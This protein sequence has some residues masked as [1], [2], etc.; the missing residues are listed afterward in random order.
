MEKLERMHEIVLISKAFAWESAIGLNS[1][2][3]SIVR[4]MFTF[5]PYPTE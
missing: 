5:V 2:M 1:E 4:T 3:I